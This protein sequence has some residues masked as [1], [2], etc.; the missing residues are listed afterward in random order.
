[1][2][3]SW[4]EG[5]AKDYLIGKIS[6]KAEREGI[7]LSELERKMLY[8]RESDWNVPEMKEMREEFNRTC[9]LDGFREKIAGLV[10]RIKVNVEAHGE[11]EKEAWD[12]SMQKLSG[13]DHYLLSM[14]HSISWAEEEAPLTSRSRLKIWFISMSCVLAGLAIVA[15]LVWYFIPGWMH[16]RWW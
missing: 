1:M 2:P 5:E 8:F 13:G 10:R 15:A 16:L 9:D 3:G 12:Q 6:S 11:L 14:M 4:T 7:P